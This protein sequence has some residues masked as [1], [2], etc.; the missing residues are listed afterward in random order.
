MIH[1][2]AVRLTKGRIRTSKQLSLLR[3]HKGLHIKS[4]LQEGVTNDILPITTFI[5]IVLC[6]FKTQN[7]HICSC[8]Y[9]RYAKVLK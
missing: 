6:L 1:T 2:A 9:T 5:G 4:V 3:E 8:T 7:H